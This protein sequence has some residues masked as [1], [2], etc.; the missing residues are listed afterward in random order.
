MRID[1]R[2]VPGLEEAVEKEHIIRNAVFF[3]D[4]EDVCGF[5]LRPMALRH[6]EVLRFASNPLLYGRPPTPGQVAQ[7]L[8]L[9]SVEHCNS[10]RVMKRFMRRVRP[11]FAPSPPIWITDNGLNRYLKRC[12]KVFVDFQKLVDGINEYIKET[13]LDRPGVGTKST[14]IQP[15]YYA[16]VVYYWG[17]FSVNGFK[18]SYNEVL[19]LPLK[20]IW[21]VLNYIKEINGKTLVNPLQAKCHEDYLTE[22]NKTLKRS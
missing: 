20:I 14:G 18:C 6:Y 16:N 3:L 21:Q 2:K 7:F 10:K 12:D 4:V 5:K 22:L 1:F 9:L 11:Y 8:W 19:D 13:M 15:G 17:L